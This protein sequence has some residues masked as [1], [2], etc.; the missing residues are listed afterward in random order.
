MLDQG[1]GGRNT[2]RLIE[3]DR[4]LRSRRPALT[5]HGEPMMQ[6]TPNPPS[7]RRP[8]LRNVA[9][10]VL[11]LGLVGLAV[12]GVLRAE[13]PGPSLNAIRD[14][15]RQRH[16]RRAMDQLEVY[17]RSHPKDASAHLLM[18]QLATEPPEP[19]PRV[20]LEHLASARPKAPREAA[21]IRFFEGKAHYQQGR[22]DLAESAWTEALELDPLVPEA[23]WALVDLL[24]K[25]G[26][27]REAH[28]VGMR[29]Y[30]V[31]P[32]PLDRAR[33]LLDMTRL[34]I[35]IV[36][37]GS[38]VLLFGPLAKEHPENLPLSLTLGLALVRDSRGAE[39]VNVLEAALRR[40]PDSPDAWDTWLTGLNGAYKAH[41]LMEE[42][43]RLPR[44]MADD[45]RFAV[46]EGI[47]AQNLGDWPR[48]IR[49]FR[50]AAAYE[51][52]NGIL[53][54]R[55]RAA[56]RQAGDRAELERVNRWYVSFEDAFRTVRAVY[57]EALATPTLGTSPHPE[58][59]HR[60]ADL[61]ERMGRPD[62]ARAWH[63]LILRDD[64]RDPVSLAALERLK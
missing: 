8:F 24:D 53:T 46:H 11:L 59:Y 47:V 52:Y 57:N 17:L 6:P 23:G 61:R 13:R 50:R 62:E 42:F 22:Y 56:L 4:A 28:R 16:F 41:R 12:L 36:A 15:A 30:Q 54:Y 26:R 34:D 64:P 35:D 7:S 5:N 43:A 55:L 63:A 1:R 45:P 3:V 60:L 29:L 19:R 2:N 51:P 14:L 32:D 18:G 44:S 21:R 9:L 20:A 48:A 40:F 38:Q 37:P 39:G 49:A 10:A 33:I 27:L 58:L 25:E 31:E